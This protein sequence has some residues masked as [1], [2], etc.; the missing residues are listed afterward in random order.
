[1]MTIITWYYWFQW[2]KYCFTLSKRAFVFPLKPI[3]WDLILKNYSP[4]PLMPEAYLPELQTV[5]TVKTH[6][7]LDPP[8]GDTE[9]FFDEEPIPT[10]PDPQRSL[11][12]GP[13]QISVWPQEVCSAG[14][15]V[16][17]SLLPGPS[18]CIHSNPC[19][20]FC[21]IKSITWTHLF[22]INSS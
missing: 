16:S 6:F 9:V 8:P 5:P 13:F 19:Y 22:I 11:T 2:N 10:H 1:M 4:L 15:Q 18:C 12:S 14:L 20:D 21:H 7:C 17:N 3:L